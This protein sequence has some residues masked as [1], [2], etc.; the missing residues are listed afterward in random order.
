MRGAMYNSRGNQCWMNCAFTLPALVYDAA[1]TGDEGDLHKLL[2]RIR[3]YLLSGNV[4]HQK[5]LTL[6]YETATFVRNHWS[7]HFPRSDTAMDDAVALFPYVLE[8]MIRERSAHTAEGW[9][10]F[11]VFRVQRIQCYNCHHVSE[12][13]EEDNFVRYG[14]DFD[15][16]PIGEPVYVQRVVDRFVYEAGYE[17]EANCDHCH[18]FA[19][20][21]RVSAPST[22]LKPSMVAVLLYR[23]ERSATRVPRLEHVHPSSVRITLCGLNYVIAG[24]CSHDGIGHWVNYLF[25]R[26]NSVVYISNHEVHMRTGVAAHMKTASVLLYKLDDGPPVNALPGYVS[27]CVLGWVD[28]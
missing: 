5:S 15:G 4:D 14:L 3:D 9:S 2:R 13:Q 20:K 25:P 6:G 7:G 22:E 11:S 12:L 26:D 10:P 8:L 21:E 23:G 24:V 19:K 1:V 16:H 28:D 27:L 17:F 18:T